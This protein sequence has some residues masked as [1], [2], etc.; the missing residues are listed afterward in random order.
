MCLVSVAS[1]EGG[2]DFLA[3]V[4]E[5][6]YLPSKKAQDCR[7]AGHGDAIV[8][9]VAGIG[10]RGREGGLALFEVVADTGCQGGNLG[11]R[12]LHFGR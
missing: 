12:G 7:D 8:D 3:L 9:R 2:E 11:L 4:E 5:G 10:N 1:R 6:V